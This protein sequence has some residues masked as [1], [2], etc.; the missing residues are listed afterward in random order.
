MRSPTHVSRHSTK[1][2]LTGEK[3]VSEHRRIRKVRN[4]G[5]ASMN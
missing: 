2:A 3:M 4:L 1:L 5:K